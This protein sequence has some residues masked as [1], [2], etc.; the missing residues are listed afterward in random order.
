MTK[1]QLPHGHFGPW[2]R[3]RRDISKGAAQKLMQMA[4]EADT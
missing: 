2:L 1:A 4:R 3:D